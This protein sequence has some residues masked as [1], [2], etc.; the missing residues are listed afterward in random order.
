MEDFLRVR[1]Y[2]EGLENPIT[3]QTNRIV[4]IFRTS[5]IEKIYSRLVEKTFQ[6]R[7]S[8]YLR[9]MGSKGFFE[10]GGAKFFP[11]GDVLTD[12]YK[13]NLRTAK[14]WLK[15]FEFVLREPTGFFARKRRISTDID[16]D[17]FLALLKEIYGIKFGG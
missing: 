2:V 14:L 15:P 16:W 1:I 11:T 6:L 12:N 4:F 9:Q 7:A 10:Y 17:V 13:I 3:V 8:S 5:N